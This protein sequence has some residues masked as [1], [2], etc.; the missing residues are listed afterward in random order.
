MAK[1]RKATICGKEVVLPKGLMVDDGGLWVRI[2]HKGEPYLKRVGGVSELNVLS[3]AKTHLNEVRELIRQGKFKIAPKVGV[4]SMNE[5]CDT[6]WEKHGKKCGS[7]RT[8]KI[9][10]D[11]IK[12]LFGYKPIHEM[13]I[14]DVKKLRASVSTHEL[15]VREGDVVKV[16]EVE[17]KPTTLNRYHQTLSAVINS[18]KRWVVTKDVPVVEL[19]EVNPC[20]YVP[21]EDESECARVRVVTPEEFKL[22]MEH[23]TIR[24]RRQVLMAVHTLLRKKD[25]ANLTVSGSV[26]WNSMVLRGVQSKV[27][28]RSKGARFAI[29]INEVVETIIKTAEGDKILDFTNHSKD[30]KAAIKNSGVEHFQFRDLRRSGARTLMRDYDIATVQGMLGHRNVQTTQLY[31]AV[32]PEEKVQA[33]RSLGKAYGFDVEGLA[34]NG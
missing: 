16:V 15:K 18:I 3:D 29:P 14:E 32:T 9:C 6:Y 5:A 26:D 24:L 31:V 7:A 12:D 4:M 23:A 11:K 17:S 8:I 20:E 25:L 34:A 30:H 28:G 22:Y 33:A 10:L 27:R 21:L 1:K 13:N 2:F 19:P